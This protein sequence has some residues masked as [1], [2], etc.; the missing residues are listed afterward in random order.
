MFW[1]H[2]IL[3][4]NLFGCSYMQ[5]PTQQHTRSTWKKNAHVCGHANA[6]LLIDTHTT[7]FLS[8]AYTKSLYNWHIRFQQ[9][10]VRAQMCGCMTIAIGTGEGGT[11]FRI[12]ALVVGDACK[13]ACVCERLCVVVSRIQYK[14]IW[15]IR[16]SWRTY[17]HSNHYYMYITYCEQTHPYREW[18]RVYSVCVF[19]YVSS[20]SFL[21]TR[22][23]HDGHLPRFI[24]TK[25]YVHTRIDYFRS[26]MSPILR[27]GEVSNERCAIEVSRWKSHTLN[28]YKRTQ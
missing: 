1:L 3:Y 18:V 23:A 17:R 27:C 21:W 12:L 9:F 4:L 15:N 8:T 2:Q 6:R 5:A 16:V 28:T 19:L 14:Y 13:R 24:N 25:T 11:W 10:I 7:R 20:P 22:D 26:I